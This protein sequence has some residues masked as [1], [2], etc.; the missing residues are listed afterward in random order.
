MGLIREDGDEVFPLLNRKT[1]V[2]DAIR[3]NG[4]QSDGEQTEE[5]ATAEGMGA[6]V[7]EVV[8]ED[9]ER[10]IERHKETFGMKF[11]RGIASAIGADEDE[12]D[13]EFIADFTETVMENDVRDVLTEEALEE[14]GINDD[15]SSSGDEVF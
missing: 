15:E 4:E 7:G 13:D 2:L 12:I 9:N 14:R 11:K 3:Q 8:L 1:P 5:S 10:K 6:S